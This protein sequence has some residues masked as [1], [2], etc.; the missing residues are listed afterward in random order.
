MYNIY[1]SYQGPCFIP[2]VL[3]ID[4]TTVVVMVTMVIVVVNFLT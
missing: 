4:T 2:E 3:V 1:K